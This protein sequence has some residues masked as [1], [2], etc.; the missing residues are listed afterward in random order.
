M[1]AQTWTIKSKHAIELDAVLNAL[2]ASKD[3]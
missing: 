1:K 2:T 3:E